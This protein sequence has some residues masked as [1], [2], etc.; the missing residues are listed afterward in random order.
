MRGGVRCVWREG[1][2]LQGVALLQA[3]DNKVAEDKEHPGMRKGAFGRLVPISRQHSSEVELPG[4]K[5]MGGASVDAEQRAGEEEQKII[6]ES[7]APA[8][9]PPSPAAPSAGVGAVEVVANQKL[10]GLVDAGVT[11][12]IRVAPWL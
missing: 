8:S 11:I 1:R 3:L 10:A 5:V 4:K 6:K 9:V 7:T 2:N 12:T